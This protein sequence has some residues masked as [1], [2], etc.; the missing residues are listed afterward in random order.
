MDLKQFRRAGFVLTLV[1]EAGISWN[2][3]NAM[4]MAAAVSYYSIFSLSPVF[5][6]AIAVASL[7]FGRE[8][9]TGQL[10]GQL[11]QWVGSEGARTIES[12]LASSQIGNSNLWATLAGVFTLLFGATGA[13]T[14]L[15]S[16]LNLIW[17]CEARP[18]M[19]WRAFLKDRFLSLV[20]VFCTG[21]LLI[22]SLGL[23]AVTAAAGSQ[24]DNWLG[25]STSKLSFMS[26]PISF[27]IMTLLFA[28]I[29]KIL[30]EVELK[31]REVAVGA[32]ATSLLFSL[33]KMLF[34]LYLGRSAISSIYGASGSLVVVMIWIYYSALILF[35]GAELTRAYANAKASGTQKVSVT[36]RNR[37]SDR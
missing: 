28:L 36:Y 3:N 7:W 22:L 18:V 5:V 25:V 1:K 11:G 15:K 20:M 9:A 12:I 34:G 21:A 19:G 27:F 32:A 23:S 8:A 29:F 17:K 13:F 30:P 37:G 16:D 26:G 6:L 14:E 24:F 33:G 35:F 2:N 31:W 4:R 10:Y